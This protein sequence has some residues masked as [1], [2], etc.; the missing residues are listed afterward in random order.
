VKRAC[1]SGVD[2]L[3]HETDT[4][5]SEIIR[6]CASLIGKPAGPDRGSRLN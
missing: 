2:L 3:R 1:D 6:E 5:L 4:H